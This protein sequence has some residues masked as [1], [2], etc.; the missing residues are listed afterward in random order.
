M[1]V[2]EG[3]RWF[4]AQVAAISAK[5]IDRNPRVPPRPRKA[6]PAPSQIRLTP[7]FLCGGLIF[8]GMSKIRTVWSVRVQKSTKSKPT[9]TQGRLRNSLCVGT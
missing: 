1:K 5:D 9:E 7:L 2:V 3:T 6:R 4:P 8:R